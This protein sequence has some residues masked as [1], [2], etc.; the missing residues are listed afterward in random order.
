VRKVA[1][2]SNQWKYLVHFFSYERSHDRWC[3]WTHVVRKNGACTCKC[4]RFFS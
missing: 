2:E 1:F 4:T 3:P